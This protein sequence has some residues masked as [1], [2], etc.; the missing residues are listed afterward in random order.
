MVT[1]KSH[2]K[3]R[4][5]L[6]A[7]GV[8]VAAS[9]LSVVTPTITAGAST[10]STLKIIT[11]VN[12]PA[13]QAFTKID[14]EFHQMYPDINV[15]LQTAVNITTGYATLLETAVDSSNADIVT[16]QTPFQPLPLNPTRTNMSIQQYWSTSGVFQSLSGQPWLN[17]LSKTAQEAETYNGNVYGVLSGVYQELVFYNKA[18]FAKYHLSVPHTYSQFLAILKTLSADHVIPLWIGLGSGASVYV[19]R[20]LAE[21]LMAEL[22]SPSGQGQNLA[23]NLEKGTVSWNSPYFQQ[24]LT[25]EATLA[26]Y[27]E[28]GYTGE[29]WQEMPGAFAENKSPMLMDGSWDLASVQ[30]ANPNLQVGSFALPGSN[31]ASQNEPVA[32]QDL[33]IE[34]LKKAPD[35][36]NALKWLDFFTTP[37]IYKQYV[38]ITGI[39][40]VEA[41]SYSSYSST[42][43][44]SLFGQGFNP[45]N[46]MPTLAE[47]QGYYD[48]PT[49]WPLLQE[50]VMAG[51]VT[52][53]AAAK[54]YASDWK[55]A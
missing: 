27:F 2:R 3:S 37:S 47:N 42:V 1:R 21:P 4:R 24:V 50:S 18:D 32:E 48:T 6:A 25:E 22:W 51:T 41:G 45:G 49:E 7:T 9:V 34:L 43:L 55:T 38:D 12:P 26:H 19:T 20:F 33:T 13:V 23:T 39:S 10:T 40:P 11:W 36:A 54:D 17:R 44:G 35:E 29:P 14:A 5:V 53:A 30:K 31:V 28:P 8:G 52:P 46:V 16:T 15:Q